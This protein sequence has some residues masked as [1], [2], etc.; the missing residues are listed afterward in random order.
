MPYNEATARQMDF[1]T[2]I[3]DLLGLTLPAEHTFEAIDK[4]I[5]HN[6]VAFYR[7]KN[8]KRKKKRKD[9]EKRTEK[10]NEEQKPAIIPD[11]EPCLT[12]KEKKTIYHDK[13]FES[14]SDVVDFVREYLHGCNTERLVVINLNPDLSII[15]ICTVA[16]GTQSSVPT[17]GKE[18]FKTAILSNAYAVMMFHNHLGSDSHPSQKDIETTKKLKMAG[19]LLELPIIDNIIITEDSYFSF[20]EFS[21][22]LD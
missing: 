18:V 13:H 20:K 21:N 6:K 16:A 17:T 2:D 5:N 3:A 12:L 8:R 4:F 15:N 10:K 22:L 9:N 7:A 11:V 1:A 19:D 14:T